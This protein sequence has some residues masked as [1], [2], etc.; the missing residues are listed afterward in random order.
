[1]RAKF[2]SQIENGRILN[3]EYRSLPGASCGAFSI[4]GPC[5]MILNIIASDAEDP[6][7]QGWEHVSVSGKRC[8]NWQEMTFVKSL[9]WDEEEVVV[10]FHPRKSEYV[11]YHPTCLHLWGRPD[12]II[13]TPPVDLVGP[14]TLDDLKRLKKSQ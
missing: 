14:R 5:G 3:G 12:G 9:F 6:I 8:P 11:S 2:S 10:Q 13:P 4:Q 1:M 7:V